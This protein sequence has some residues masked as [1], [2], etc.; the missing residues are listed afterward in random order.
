MPG[1]D[2][3]TGSRVFAHRRAPDAPG[4]PTW[5]GGHQGSSVHAKGQAPM[6]PGELVE[7]AE[8]VDRGE[9][10]VLPEEGVPIGSRFSIVP[11]L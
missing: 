1:C 11:F 7:A 2:R 4:L 5:R 8:R 6:P 3:F 9:G 10:P